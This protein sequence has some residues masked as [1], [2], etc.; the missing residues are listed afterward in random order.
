MFLSLSSFFCFT[1]NVPGF[2]SRNL[3]ILSYASNVLGMD[4][5]IIG[6]PDR[7]RPGGEFILYMYICKEPYLNAGCCAGHTY[8]M[9]KTENSF[10][11]LNAISI[12]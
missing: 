3:V 11:R 4:W 9:L 1:L 8:Q 5:I 6:K 10:N 2:T 12:V 7:P